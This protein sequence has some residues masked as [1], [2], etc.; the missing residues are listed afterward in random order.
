MEL[1]TWEG[2]FAAVFIAL[3]GGPFLVGLALYLGADDFQI[4]LLGAIPFLAQITQL[5]AAYKVDSHGRCKGLTIKSL[6]IS[7]QIWWLLL[8]LPLLAGKWR[9]MWMMG[10]FIVSSIGATMGAAGWFTWMADLI[11][12]RV[13]GR[14][15]GFRGAA[16]AFST[17]LAF[18]FAGVVLD[19]FKGAGNDGQGFAV[20]IATSSIAGLLAAITMNKIPDRR[21]SPERIILKRDY[22]LEPLRNIEFRR[23]MVIFFVWNLGTGIAA[24]FF[25]VHMLTYLKMSFTLVSLYSIAALIVAIITNKAWGILID[26][27]GPRPIM[28]YCMF[29]LALVPLIWL[30]ITPSNLWILI[31]EVIY[32]G[33]LWAGFNLAAFS[34]PLATSP[35]RNRTIYL[36]TLAVISGIGFF[37][38]SVAGGALANVLSGM[39]FA[40][41]PLVLINYQILFIIS[42]IIRLAGALVARKI[43]GKS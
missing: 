10:I 30:I 23:L 3:T 36:A 6:T 43:M 7:R 12:G 26:R 31:F 14:Y 16:V 28:T 34:L 1:I 2:V 40:M 39:N 32:A 5:A 8:P 20:I 21:I 9:L 19:Y 17:I 25:A 29:G 27:H 15:F 37:A 24:S 33:A 22:F 35:A 41:G 11:P 4:G 42:A 13:R 18:V 38:A